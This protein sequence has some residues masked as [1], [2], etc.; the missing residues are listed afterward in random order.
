MLEPRIRERLGE[1]DI[2]DNLLREYIQTAKDRLCLRLGTDTLP[3]EFNSICV[4]AVVKMYRRY[5]Y[6]G[7]SS[8]NDGGLS[9]TFAEDVLS[10]YAAEIEAY[11][12]KTQR[13]AVKF[14]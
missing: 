2:N 5:C 8:E 10:E 3:Y 6:E 11:R 13:R 14:I 9:V 7:I 4:D 1:E 12:D